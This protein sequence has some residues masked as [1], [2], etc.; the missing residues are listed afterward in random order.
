MFSYAVVVVVVVVVVVAVV[1]KER[2]PLLLLFLVVKSKS[3]LAV[4]SMSFMSSF[5]HFKSLMAPTL[6]KCH[7]PD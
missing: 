4:L 6:A 5:K 2:Y 1:V 3:N 7:E